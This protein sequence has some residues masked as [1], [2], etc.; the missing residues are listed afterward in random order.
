MFATHYHMLIDEFKFFPSIGFYFMNFMEADK[1]IIF[2]YQLTKGTCH[3]SFGISVARMVG[4]PDK[5]HAMALKKCKEFEENV[6]IS[7]I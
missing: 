5:I 3:N 7:Q 6:N 2:L 4:L 1:K